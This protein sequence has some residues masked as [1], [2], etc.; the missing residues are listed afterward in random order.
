MD[1]FA[2]QPTYQFRVRAGHKQADGT[3]TWSK[4]QSGGAVHAHRRRRPAPPAAL[5]YGGN[6]TTQSLPGV[7][8]ALAPGACFGGKATLVAAAANVAAAGMASCAGCAIGFMTL[9]C[10]WLP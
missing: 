2:N 3:T 4:W 9:L 7:W 6:W 10:I 5:N 8:W 1:N